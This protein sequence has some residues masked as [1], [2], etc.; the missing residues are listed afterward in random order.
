M[1]LEVCVEPGSRRPDLAGPLQDLAP[2]LGQTR[3]AL[4]RALAAIEGRG[5]I[6]RMLGATKPLST[7]DSNHLMPLTGGLCM[8]VNGDTKVEAI[9]CLWFLGLSF[10]SLPQRRQRQCFRR[11]SSPKAC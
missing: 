4:Y 7:H 5:A 2:Q 8:W 10:L 9:A 6:R 3:E 11:R 1:Y